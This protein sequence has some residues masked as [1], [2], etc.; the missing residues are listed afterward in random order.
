MHFVLDTSGYIG[1][2]NG[3]HQITSY[4]ADANTIVVPAIIIGELFYGYHKGSRYQENTKVL[5]RFLHNPRV[6]TVAVDT[7]T[8]ERYGK[9][10]HEQYDAG[11]ILADNDLWIAAVCLQLGLPLLTFD[12]DFERVTDKAFETLPV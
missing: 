2:L 4:I 12:S 3:D 5:E 8:A 7:K 1:I 11:E 6:I 10:K 9:L